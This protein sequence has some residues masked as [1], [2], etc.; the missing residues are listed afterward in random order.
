MTG[1][2]WSSYPIL[3]QLVELD[4]WLTAFENVLQCDADAPIFDD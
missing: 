1:W 2:I 3:S 4:T